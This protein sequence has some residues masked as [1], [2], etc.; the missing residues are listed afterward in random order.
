MPAPG[1]DE[2]RTEGSKYLPRVPAYYGT[3]NRSVP[4]NRTVEG[5]KEKVPELPKVYLKCLKYLH[6]EQETD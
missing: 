2:R 3:G 5:D 1:T 4:T 6:T